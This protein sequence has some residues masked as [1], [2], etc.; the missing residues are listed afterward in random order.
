MEQK[1]KLSDLLDAVH[2]TVAIK[3]LGV[4]CIYGVFESTLSKENCHAEVSPS[5]LV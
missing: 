2:D 1:Y 4:R 5:G 3:S